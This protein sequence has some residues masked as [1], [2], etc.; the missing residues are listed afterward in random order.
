MF[1]ALAS[2][3]IP[4]LLALAAC[5]S[6]SGPHPTGPVVENT[7]TDHG[8]VAA[9]AVVIKHGPMT[10]VM[11]TPRNQLE[12][13]RTALDQSGLVAELTAEGIAITF[14]ADPALGDT[15]IVQAGADELGRAEL[16]DLDGKEIPDALRE[17][18]HARFPAAH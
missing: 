18:I 2:H 8:E 3:L 9:R 4:G 16:H 13:A 12:K 1:K 6:S 17:A 11:D 5:G 7:A 14:E 15:V 10:Y